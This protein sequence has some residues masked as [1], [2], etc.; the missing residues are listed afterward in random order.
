M[1]AGDTYTSWRYD[2]SS[3]GKPRSFIM[4]RTGGP[5]VRAG[6]LPRT[7]AAASNWAM[8]RVA[9]VPKFPAD[10]RSRL[11]LIFFDISGC[12]YFWKI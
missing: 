10:A 9:G 11:L 6:R 12:S 7:A 4:R 3:V 5:Q 1:I 8:A 2:E